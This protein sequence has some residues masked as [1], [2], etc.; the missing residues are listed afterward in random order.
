MKILF[1][2]FSVGGFDLFSRRDMIC[3]LSCHHFRAWLQRKLRPSLNATVPMLWRHRKRRRNG[4]NSARTSLAAFLCFCGSEPSFAS[5]PI[6]S[7]SA[8]K[9]MSSATTYVS[10][11]LFPFSSSAIFFFFS[12]SSFA[13]PFSSICFFPFLVYPIKKNDGCDGTNSMMAAVFLLSYSLF[14][15]SSLNR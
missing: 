13:Q 8:L 2:V 9:R 14:S 5:S 7:K 10:F 12:L 15:F 3:Y 6:R 1:F 4:W 11:I